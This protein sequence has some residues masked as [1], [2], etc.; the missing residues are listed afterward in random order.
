MVVPVSACRPAEVSG[1]VLDLA[2]ITKRFGALLAND[3]ISLVLH[4]G[5]VLALLGENGAGNRPTRVK[6]RR[7]CWWSPPRLG[8]HCLGGV[9][10]PGE[11]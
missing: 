6:P 3:D 7:A 11:R 9:C 1:P 2:G 8:L 4:R 10:V 5:E